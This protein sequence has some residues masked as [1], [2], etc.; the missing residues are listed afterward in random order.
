M[1][2]S[3]ISCTRGGAEAVPD[4]EGEAGDHITRT[5]VAPAPRAPYQSVSVS[6]GGTISGAVRFN[7]ELQNDSTTVL[8]E[9]YN[10]CNKRLV[11]DEFSRINGRVE[12]AVVWLLDIR[13]GKHPPLNRRY[14]VRKKNCLLEPSLQ[15]AMV[16]G[17]VN[18]TNSDAVIEQANI[19][20][21]AT[22]KSAGVAPFSDA[23]QV[24]PNFQMLRSTGA[25]E[26]FI[27]SRP[28][29]RAWV[30]ALDHPYYAITDKQGSFT[31]SN[32]PSGTYTLRVWHPLLGTLDMVVEVTG[33][34][35]TTVD[36]L[37]PPAPQIALESIAQDN[38]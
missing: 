22:G 34:S 1:V 27:E 32:V 7:G 30:V 21:I 23:G 2:A 4:E 20:N 3:V 37:F 12:N 18:L 26:I 33:R 16:G 28:A 6:N 17:N 5:T 24:V 13:L 11:I 10:S 29:S 36:A 25:Y 19:V 9:D 35:R 14:E 8:P 38:S 31:I 15:V